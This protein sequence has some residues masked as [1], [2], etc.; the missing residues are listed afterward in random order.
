MSGIDNPAHRREVA[1]SI[2]RACN[3]SGFFQVVGHGI[4][5][6]LRERMLAQGRE[7]FA[8]PGSEKA[9]FQ[10]DWTE[11]SRPV[12]GQ[13][14]LTA[15]GHHSWRDSFRHKAA[16]VSETE[17]EEWPS[18]PAAYRQT[19]KD[20]SESARNLSNTIFQ[21]IA[22]GLNLKSNCL[23]KALGGEDEIEYT[24]MLGYYPRCPRPD[25]ALGL[26]GHTDPN[27][28][29]LL[30]Q[31]EPGLEVI[32]DGL[33]IPVDPAPNGF[34]VNVGDTFQIMTNDRYKSSEHRVLASARRD[35][36]S[37]MIFVQPKAHTNV[38]VVPDLVLSGTKPV[39]DDIPCARHL[40]NSRQGMDKRLTTLALKTEC[41]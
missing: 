29:T 4:P 3:D 21:L 30:V 40:M 16:P 6:E 27:P 2:A 9:K 23:I 18:K 31:D 12:L 20:F 11:K 17:V 8:L 35:R 22:E 39:F 28:L 19:V 32:K 1:A 13:S 25:E 37:A 41:N 7:F 5:A 15:S 26:V 10:N 38:T 33:W 36:A 14:R 24:V 34:V